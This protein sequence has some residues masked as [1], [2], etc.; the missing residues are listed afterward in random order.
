MD[1]WGNLREIEQLEDLDEDGMI[2]LKHILKR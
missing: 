1:W 2:I